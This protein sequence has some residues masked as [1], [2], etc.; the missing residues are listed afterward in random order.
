[1]KKLFYSL[2][3]LLGLISFNKVIAQDVKP[4]HFAFNALRVNDTL[5]L[6]KVKA[7]IAMHTQLFSVKKRNSDD[8][9]VSSLQ[10]DSSMQAYQY[11]SDTLTEIGNL[12]LVKEGAS[13][14]T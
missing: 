10:L 7:T 3:F 5:A 4:V 14:A 1:M 9:F 12:R 2:V 11:T 6:L 8:P 13:D